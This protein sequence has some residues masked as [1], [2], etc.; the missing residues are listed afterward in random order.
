[1]NNFSYFQPPIQNTLPEKSISLPDVVDLI[2]TGKGFQEII[3]KLRD[4]TDKNMKE[5][6]P[7]VTF[8][9]EFTRRNN[10]GLIQ[11][12][13]LL[14][15]DV[16]DQKVTLED[17]QDYVPALVFTSPS[18]TGQKIVY[19]I[20]IKNGTH[21]DY[22]FALESYFK[23][24]HNIAIDKACKDVQRACWLSHDPSV[25]L[26]DSP[27]VL[28]KKFITEYYKEDTEKAEQEEILQPGTRNNT[29]FDMALE[30]SK[31][32]RK[33]SDVLNEFEKY[34]ADDFPLKEIRQIVNSAFKYKPGDIPY[35]RVGVN[36]FKVIQ[37]TDRHGI[38]R[39]ELK[40]WNKDTLIEDHKRKYLAYVPKYDDFTMLPDNINYKPVVNGCYNLYAPFSHTPKKGEHPWS[41]KM[42]EHVF[43]DQLQQGLRYM[44]I[45]YLHPERSTIVLVLVSKENKTG[46]TT[47][48][49]WLHMLFGQ[50]VALLS[51][52]DF[53]S[54]FNSSYATKNLLIIEETL[55]EKRLTIEKLKSLVTSKYIQV[56][57][58]FVTPYKIPFH[59]K[60]VLTSNNVDKFALVDP[61]ET[62][63]FVLKLDK[64]T[65][66][67]AN[68]EDDLLKEIPAFLD[69]L[70]TLQPVDWSVDR[71]GFTSAEIANENLR[72][73]QYESRSSLYKELCEYITDFF[74]NHETKSELRAAPKD[75]KERWFYSDA[76]IGASYI[77]RVL[78]DDFELIA[79]KIS[80]YSPFDDIDTK[81]GRPYRFQR[82]YFVT[83]ELDKKNAENTQKNEEWMEVLPF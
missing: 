42:M 3:K 6:L 34:V 17:M 73:V 4:T 56:N 62:R 23:Q 69:Y 54:G 24:R 64:P 40:A 83:E 22:Y 9:G 33:K 2:R 15:V 52:S 37:K 13:G 5:R 60:V 35:I 36:Y 53:T 12:S 8:S 58:K 47:F 25:V 44:Q 65:M 80:R 75:I 29:L 70:R 76:R 28:D 82:S 7:Y 49:N 59:G 18:G 10:S 41:M 43:G 68:I 48:C 16:D 11:H 72:A 57:Q 19:A 79:D 81:V 67:N 50:N 63:F 74:L 21:L 45:L 31:T 26:N 66:L 71:S 27:T 30:A 14:C 1:M 20:D 39:R 77:S 51:S 32:G 38:V 46:K 61:K 78:R 55:L